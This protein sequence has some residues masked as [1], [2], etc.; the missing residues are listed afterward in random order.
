VTATLRRSALAIT[1]ASCAFVTAGGA[2]AVAAA[3]PQVA[4]ASQTVVSGKT[5]V[6][7]NAKTLKALAADGYTLK[8]TG[9][10]GVKGTTLTLP[11]T[12]GTYNQGVGTVVQVGGFSITKG[13]KSVTVKDLII[14]LK[15]GS[16]TAIVTGHG[17]IT[18]VT[19]GAPQSGSGG[20]HW[21]SYGGFTVS[22]SSA[23]TKVLD[24]T[25]STKAF[26]K[27]STLGVGSTRLNF[28][29]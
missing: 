2:A 27:H 5:A 21:V 6:E 18:A 12:G 7:L 22:F 25:F 28:K 4:S 24:G 20:A 19:V 9:K 26:A 13:S 14:H 29:R 16:A 11:V 1:A 3:A 15:G 17:R 23:A 8:A 10:G